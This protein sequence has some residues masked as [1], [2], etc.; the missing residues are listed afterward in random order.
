MQAATYDAQLMMTT[1][2]KRDHLDNGT[3]QLFV[4]SSMTMNMTDKISNANENEAGYDNR[5]RVLL[6]YT[7]AR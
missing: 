3:C 6:E 4:P 2:T 7:A 5:L 1:M